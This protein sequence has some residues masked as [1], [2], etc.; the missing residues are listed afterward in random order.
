VRDDLILDRRVQTFWTPGPAAAAPGPYL[1]SYTE[2]T[3]HTLRDLPAIYLA[4]R[5]L[6]DACAELAGAVGV[7]FYWQVL[8][9][10]AGSL[11]V[12]ES[13]AALRGFVALPYHLEIMRRYRDRGTLRAI[14]WQADR[15]GVRAAMERGQR[16]LDD[17]Q[18]RQR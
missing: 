16:M 10:R 2:F 11:S 15:F 4:A 5:K 9:R 13:E 1:V 8:R 14:S 7:G 17:G 12:W 18:G 3:P 6:R